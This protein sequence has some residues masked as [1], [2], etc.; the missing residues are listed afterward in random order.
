M[1]LYHYT[2]IEGFDQIQ[3]EGVVR[4]SRDG[5]AGPGVYLT[6]RDPYNHSKEEIASVNYLGGGQRNL[7]RGRLDKY[8][9]FEIPESKVKFVRESVFVLPHQDLKLGEFPVDSGLIDAAF[10]NPLGVAAVATAAL[11][12][13][14]L[15]LGAWKS[16]RSSSQRS[17]Q[18]ILDD[19]E[20][21][22]LALVQTL[23]LARETMS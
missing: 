12:V 16:W 21:Q 7:V 8:F 3:R 11:L 2:S 6:D 13:G 9:A 1:K 14:D 23:P 22:M 10:G 20:A 18:K 5:R 19:V 15:A 4:Q 17:N